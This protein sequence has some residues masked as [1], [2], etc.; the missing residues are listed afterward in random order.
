M[1]FQ[2]VEPCVTRTTLTCYVV[3]NCFHEVNPIVVGSITQLLNGK[4]LKWNAIKAHARPVETPF[5]S[6]YH[7]FR[8]VTQTIEATFLRPVFFIF[9]FPLLLYPPRA[10]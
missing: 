2:N 1:Q 5:L 6:R 4:R 7:L 3:F 8:N 9:Q 10:P